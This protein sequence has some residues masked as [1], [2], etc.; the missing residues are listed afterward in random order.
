MGN[1]VLVTLSKVLL[2]MII[3][4]VYN[5]ENIHGTKPCL[6][7]ILWQS[8]PQMVNKGKCREKEGETANGAFTD[9]K[10]NQLNFLPK[11]TQERAERSW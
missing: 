5:I 10:T 11:A 4:S 8:L 9:L 7:H 6:W 3:V 1:L 2:M